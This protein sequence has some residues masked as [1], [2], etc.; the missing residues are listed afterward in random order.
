MNLPFPNLEHRTMSMREQVI[1]RLLEL[2]P[3]KRRSYLETLPDFALLESLQVII[4]LRAE[5]YVEDHGREMFD[6]GM[7]YERERII[8]QLSE[9]L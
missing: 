6:A 8:N 9:G 5:R 4:E 1:E 7:D 3:T 2:D